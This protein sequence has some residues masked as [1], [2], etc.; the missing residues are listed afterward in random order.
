MSAINEYP[1]FKSVNE[2]PYIQNLNIRLNYAKDF[3][4]HKVAY[5]EQLIK[6]FKDRLSNEAMKDILN[7]NDY[8]TS[9]GIHGQIFVTPINKGMVFQKSFDNMKQAYNFYINE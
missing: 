4:P 2:M 6:E 8:K 7:N 3:T 9:V 1:K 5:Y